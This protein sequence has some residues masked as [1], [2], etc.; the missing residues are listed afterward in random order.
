MGAPLSLCVL[1]TL[2]TKPI[3]LQALSFDFSL[4]HYKTASQSSGIRGIC[5]S[6]SHRQ[7]WWHG[8]I[9]LLQ[10]AFEGDLSPIGFLSFFVNL[11]L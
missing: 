7:Q 9:S 3:N 10:G 1:V 5:H 6:F 2:H 4:L 8:Q 11:Q